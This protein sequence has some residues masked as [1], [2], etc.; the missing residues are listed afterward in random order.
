MKWILTKT[1]DILDA[2]L[3]YE[4]A[5]T[6]L[7]LPESGNILAKTIQVPL[8]FPQWSE[9]SRSCNFVNNCQGT[10]GF[11]GTILE[12]DQSW[13]LTM[14]TLANIPRRAV[15]IVR[16]KQPENLGPGTPCHLRR[17]RE[18]YI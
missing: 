15:G 18:V 14:A 6:T 12:N 11:D 10:I 16:L 17:R 4:E 5:M 8:A 13:L 7:F 9:W 2:P 1:L 3:A